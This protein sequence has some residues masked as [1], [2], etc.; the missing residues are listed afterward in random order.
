MHRDLA[1]IHTQAREW[2]SACAAFHARHHREGDWVAANILSDG[3]NAE[4]ILRIQTQPE[5]NTPT[6]SGWME[7]SSIESRRSCCAELI[8]PSLGGLR[9]IVTELGHE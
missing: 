2:N 4:T 1:P 7:S 8:A 6:I 3:K 9:L 5:A